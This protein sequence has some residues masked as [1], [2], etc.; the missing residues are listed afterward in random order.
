MLS[1]I[2]TKI[3]GATIIASLALLVSTS[4]FAANTLSNTSSTAA[5]GSIVLTN[6]SA[7]A[8][9]VTN[10]DLIKVQTKISTPGADVTVLV[11]DASINPATDEISDSDIK[12]IDQTPSSESTGDYSVTF[13][14]PL[15]ASAGK[16][17]IYIGGSG[18]EDTTV[19]YMNLTSSGIPYISGDIDSSNEVDIAD[20]IYILRYTVGYD[21][22]AGTTWDM[23]AADVDD[24]SEV[25]IADAIYILR[26]TVGYDAPAG[27]SVGEQLTRN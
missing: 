1:S 21:A 15:T 24:S 7:D 5:S 9:D 18:V 22:P 14:M 20:A 6:T 25:D 13:R 8:P 26:Y 27:V 12:Y 3:F 10:S 23:D 4:A 11:L 19:K 16:Y 2:K 17:A